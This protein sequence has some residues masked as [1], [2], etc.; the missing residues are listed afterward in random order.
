M[1]DKAAFLDLDSYIRRKHINFGDP[2]RGM[3]PIWPVSDAHLRQAI[4]EGWFPAGTRISPRVT[5][6]R[7][8]DVLAALDKKFAEAKSN[9]TANTPDLIRE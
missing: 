6:Y 9:A 2:K 4:A 7:L 3:K 8:S 1:A 5:V